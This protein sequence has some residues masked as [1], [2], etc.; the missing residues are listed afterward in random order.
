MT[1][2]PAFRYSP[3]T[4]T[5]SAGLRQVE[6]LEAAV[7]E[8]ALARTASCPWR[9]RRRARDRS[10]ASRKGFTE[11]GPTDGAQRPSTRLS[12]PA[13][14]RS[15]G[16]RG[17]EQLRLVPHEVVLAVDRE[18]VVLAHEDRRHRAGLFAVAAEDAARLVNLVD[19]RVARAGHH[20]AVVL[21]RFEIDRVGR[22]RHRAQAAGHA[23]LQAVLV[24]HQHLFAAIPRE[25]RHLLVRVVHG[26]GPPEQVLE[27]ER[28][29]VRSTGESWS[30]PAGADRAPSHRSIVAP[31]SPPARHVIAPTAFVYHR[32]VQRAGKLRPPA[33]R[34]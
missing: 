24:A 5:T 8:D 27:G 23:L 10:N 12:A 31:G 2:A 22:A 9:R 21:G 6:R 14:R 4:S 33:V 26:D 18:L 19:R 1:S 30:S 7:D 34:N 16:R 11:V 32:K 13:R 25:H 17:H 29:A 28:K 20:R 15:I 3:C